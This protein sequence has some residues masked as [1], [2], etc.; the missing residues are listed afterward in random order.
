MGVA[1]LG[2]R[3]YSFTP[4]GDCFK[5]CRF[6]GEYW[7]GRLVTNLC[8][9]AAMIL[10]SSVAPS[11]TCRRKRS[12][13]SLLPLRQHLNAAGKRVNYDITKLLDTHNHPA[14]KVSAAVR[15]VSNGKSV[16]VH[17]ALRAGYFLAGDVVGHGLFLAFDFF[18]L[19]INNTPSVPHGAFSKKIMAINISVP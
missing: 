14:A 1:I 4:Y 19:V 8:R 10:A 18:Y 17:S 2:I 7:E 3:T 5:R 12:S 11:Y 6:S 16:V 9:A 13:K 15:A